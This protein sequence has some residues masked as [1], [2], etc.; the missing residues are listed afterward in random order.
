MLSVCFMAKDEMSEDFGSGWDI[1]A[2]SGALECPTQCFW[3][4]ETHLCTAQ[5]QQ[6]AMAPKE[7][8]SWF[9]VLLMV[10]AAAAVLGAT[11][12]LLRL[13]PAP[14]SDISVASADDVTGA[15]HLGSD[16]QMSNSN[17]WNQGVLGGKR[18]FA[19]DQEVE[20]L[21]DSSERYSREDSLRSQP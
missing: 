17:N 1:C 5:L 15:Y 4:V 3:C 10:A 12:L 9:P 11:L 2:A 20:G 7:Q 6:C 8:G 18:T 16:V 14:Q 19:C 13:R 21:L